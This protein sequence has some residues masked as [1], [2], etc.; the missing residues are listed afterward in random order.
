MSKDVGGHD[1]DSKV[2]SSGIGGS[3]VETQMR[4]GHERSSQ[5]VG[6]QAREF[7][8]V[9]Y[10]DNGMRATF[11][12]RW[13][14]ILLG[15]TLIITL[16]LWWGLKPLYGTIHVGICRTLIQLQLKYPATLKVTAVE[17]FKNDLR[18]YITYIDPFGQD[19]SDMFECEFNPD[20]TLIDARI[21]RVS[22]GA[23]KVEAFNKSIP[24]VI[25]AD[26]DLTIAPP[27]T[28]SIRGL[29]KD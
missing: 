24:M 27:P 18:F 28:T 14:M 16:F 5:R 23:D 10:V 9:E 29:K 4:S 8:A 7:K 25:A 26:P 3:A 17:W 2:G 11:R 19:R 22:I 12:R 1:P 20:L 21:N 15:G 13:K 6:G